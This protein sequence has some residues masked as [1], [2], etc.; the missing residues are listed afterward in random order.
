MGYSVSGTSFPQYV[1][2]L[3]TCDTSL[4]VSGGK[5]VLSYGSFGVLL[6]KS[7]VLSCLSRTDRHVTNSR[8][9]PKPNT[10][11]QTFCETIE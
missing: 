10:F 1:G 3:I 2:S 8:W 9:I 11:L 6:T 5:G 7:V 4:P